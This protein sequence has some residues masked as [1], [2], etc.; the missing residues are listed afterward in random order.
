MMKKGKSNN[1]SKKISN[2]PSK[3]CNPNTSTS[4][5]PKSNSHMHKVMSTYG[6]DYGK[7]GV[8]IGDSLRK[9]GYYAVAD[10]LEYGK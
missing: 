4:W 6:G 3:Q 7:K 8:E 9:N 2:R 1:V 10:F 5:K